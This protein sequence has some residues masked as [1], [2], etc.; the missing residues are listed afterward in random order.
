MGDLVMIK[1]P[2]SL[3]AGQGVHAKLSHDHWTA[4]R[5]VVGI[6]RLGPS[7]VVNLNGHSIGR[8]TVL[9]A[10]VKLFYLRPVDLRH[11]FEDVFAHAAWGPDLGLAE[12]STA[13]L[14]VYTLYDHKA[15]QGKVDIWSW[16]Y[17]GRCQ[18]GAEYQRLTKYEAKDSFTPL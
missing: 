18:D 8:R 5:K 4:P 14:P 6:P 1:E 3:L 12:A 15:V 11:E 16:Q 10:N 17:R 13:A 9:V 2:D 7:L